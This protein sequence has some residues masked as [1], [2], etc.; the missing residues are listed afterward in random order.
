MYALAISQELSMAYIDSTG[1]AVILP[2]A[3][4]ALDDG[5]SPEAF[6]KMH[7]ELVMRLTRSLR[8]AEDYDFFHERKGLENLFT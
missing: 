4:N 6:E 7:G 3:L 8:N 2:G 5:P 1:R